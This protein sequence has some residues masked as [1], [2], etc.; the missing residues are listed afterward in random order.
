MRKISKENLLE[1]EQHLSIIDMLFKYPDGLTLHELTYL[2]TTR[3]NMKKM[4]SLQRDFGN[5]R[6]NI[7]KTRQRIVDCLTDIKWMRKKEGKKYVL[8]FHQLIT[9]VNYVK[10]QKLNELITKKLQ[11]YKP[12]KLILTDEEYEQMR[13]ELI[14]SR[15]VNSH[16]PPW[17]TNLDEINL[18]NSL[19]FV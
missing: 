1:K 13:Y 8:D 3:K 11:E 5:E 10:Q 16:R 14:G 6:R 2:L 9:W 4:S 18:I 7:F 19:K 12:N 17:R 15:K